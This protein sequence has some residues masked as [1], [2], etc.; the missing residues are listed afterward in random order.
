MI[1]E[2]QI[3]MS[4][5][6]L[7]RE[8]TPLLRPNFVAMFNTAFRKSV[9]DGD[10]HSVGS[11]ESQRG[12][13]PSVVAELGFLIGAQQVERQKSNVEIRD[14]LE[15]LEACKDKAQE[16][17]A[18]YDELAGIEISESELEEAIEIAY[19]Y[20]LLLGKKPSSVT[21]SP[22]I[23]GAGIVDSCEADIADGECLWEVKAVRRNVSGKDI[24]QLVVY[25]ALNYAS[26]Q[27]NW[28]HAGI[29]NPRLSLYF[30]FEVEHLIGLLS[31][32]KSAGEVFHEMATY[33]SSREIQI[34]TE[35]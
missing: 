27:N 13:N 11:V 19:R 17:I 9:L 22:L 32:G 6:D 10:G 14:F 2:R 21:F 1:S 15:I 5:D 25:L 8:A 4:F 23:P 30:R 29:F 16:R 24:R 26:G 28:T 31:G 33:F 18:R 3:A 7:W 12:N 20:E 34:D 35:F